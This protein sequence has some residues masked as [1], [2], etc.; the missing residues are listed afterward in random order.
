MISSKDPIRWIDSEEALS[1]PLR[2]ALKSGRAVRPTPAQID[3]LSKRL[4]PLFEAGLPT[5]QPDRGLTAQA[6]K[7][8]GTGFGMGKG[9]LAVVVLA[10]AAPVIWYTSTK[11]IR[12]SVIPS[13]PASANK[14]QVT[15]KRD[16]QVSIINNPLTNKPEKKPLTTRFPIAP[17]PNISHINR[18]MRGGGFTKLAGGNSKAVQEY[19]IERE[20]GLIRKARK[21]LIPAPRKALQ[22]TEQHLKEFEDGMFV[23][24][25]EI[26]AIEALVN[27]G[28]MERAK[29][30][31][32]AL[33]QAYPRSAYKRRI[34]KIFQ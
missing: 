33:L 25:R 27:I 3:D 14:P 6:A 7:T 21:Q 1:E 19:R 11:P 15:S 2:N 4:A 8:T 31:A 30:R 5:V 34:E 28:D 9:L 10:V 29:A 26:I 18:G 24:E 13:A 12:E 20:I 23:Q 22:L 32:D 17:K 16:S